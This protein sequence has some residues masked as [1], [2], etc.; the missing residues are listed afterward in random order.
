MPA[1]T[2]VASV[3]ASSIGAW[4]LG[5]F[6][7]SVVTGAIATGLA[8]VTSRIINGN[9]NKGNNSAN[10][11][12]GRI[13]VPPATNNKI[14]V[15]YGSA[16]VNGIITD[17]RLKSSDNIKNDTMYYCLVL[18]E[19]TNNYTTPSYGIE[20]V[21]WN[22]L[23]LTADP[24]D[25]E[26]VKDGRKVVDGAIVTAG[27][28]LTDTTYVI[29]K[30]GTTD[31]TALGAQTNNIGQVFTA[32]NSGLFIAG[33]FVVG[34][35]YTIV[36]LGSTNFTLIGAS[37]NTVGITFTATGV[38]VGSGTASQG[39]GQAQEED[40]KDESFVLDNTT[41][42]VE[43]RVYAGGSAAAN[44]IYPPQS[45]GQTM[46]A[47]EFWADNDGSWTSANEMKGLVFAIIKMK[48]NDKG[49]TS[50]PN[51]TFQLA[52]N[53][54]NPADVWYDYMTSVRYGAGIAAADLDTTALTA[55]RNFCAEDISYTG[56][57]LDPAGGAGTANQVLDR[58]QINGILD[59]SNQVKTNI[60]T[61]L[62]NGGAWMSY[63]VA[64][65]L[66]SPVIKKAVSA[67]VPGETA[68]YFTA[69]KS[70]TT[71]TVATFPNGR[72]EAGQSLYNSTG[73]LIGTISA[74]LAPTTG[75]TAGQV[76]RY[77]ISGAA[78]TI[79]TTTFYTVAPSLLSF[80][81][82]N[83]I[84]GISIS[85][86]RLEDLYNKVE[87]E[88]YDKYNKDQ[89]A[90]YRT[91]VASGELNPNEPANTLRMNLDLCNNSVQSDLIGQVEL[92]QSRDD[93]VI[94]FT[95]TFYGIQAQAGDVIEV[96][97]DLYGWAP[98]L[99]RVMRV[100]EQE[101]EDGGL[102][103]Q[104]QALE[105]NPDAY[106]IEPITEFTT[107]AN[108]GIGNL[109]SSVGL[110]PPENP[111]ITL[112]NPGASVPNFTFNVD[113]PST[114]GPF[115]EIEV[116]YTEG[117]DPNSVTGTI[118]PGTGSNGVPVGKGL[119][120]V[121]AVTYNS[122]NVGDYFDL[123]GVTVES[124]LTQTTISTKT[125]SSGGAIGAFTF[126]LNNVTGVVIGQK[127]TG[128]GIPS[129]A[130]VVGVSGT[131]VT[132]DKAFTVQAAGS[133]L[134]TT[135]GGTGTY[136][137]SIST[138]ASGT[139]DLFDEPLDTD[140]IFLKN[141]VPDGNAT[142]FPSPST[143][144]ILIT[145]L[146]ANSQTFR[147][148][149]LKSRLGNKKNFGGFS[150]NVPIDIDGNN[151]N[152]Q[153]NPTSAGR[154]SD[155]SD[156]NIT[157]IAEGN[158]LYYDATTSKWRNT[159]I[160]EI[161]DAPAG[162][163]FAR[164]NGILIVENPVG[165]ATN[166]FNRNTAVTDVGVS[167]LNIKATSTGTPAV[168]FGAGILAESEMANTGIE[169]VGG[170]FWIAT[171]MTD[172]A[173]DFQCQI[174]AMKNGALPDY[175]VYIDS[176]G[177]LSADGNLTLNYDQ[178]AGNAVINA[179]SGATLGT[180]TW[181]GT[182]WASSADISAP[183]AT[184]GNITVGVSTNNTITT[185]SGDLILDSVTDLV[186]VNA[187]LVVDTPGFQGGNIRSSGLN[188][189]ITISQTTTSTATPQNGLR[190][191]VESTGV[192]AVGLGT[193]LE[194]EIETASGV[195]TLAGAVQVQST[196]ITPGAESFKMEFALRSAG[197]S[198][199]R[200][201][202]DHLGN[203]Q[204]DG[205]LTVT[206]TDISTGADSAIAINRD[207]STT[208]TALSPLLLRRTTSGTPAVGI[209]TGITFS[210]ETAVGNNV[211]GG[212]ID[213][214]STDITPGSESF[215]MDFELRNGGVSSAKKMSLD[216]LGNLQID[217]DLTVTGNNIKSS[218][219][220]ALTLSGANVTVAGTLRTSSSEDVANA[221]AISLTTAV[222]YFSTT[223]S[224][225]ATL[226]AGS[227]GQ[228]KSLMMVADGGDMVV[229][230][231]NAG[232]KT[233]GTGTITF[234]DIGD[235]CLLQYINSKWFAVGVNGVTFA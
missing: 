162:D 233:S 56:A 65:G 23:R 7:L 182:T 39:T 126:L 183:S 32:T 71:L 149:F 13:Q 199:T 4:A 22:D 209:G 18:S 40:F 110:P 87:V 133:Y 222:S 82:D 78:S 220:I 148:Y 106:T 179:Y 186:D 196:D 80:S 94:E 204:I 136:Q 138:T 130:M 75:E 141:K 155:L 231:T 96:T 234:N 111:I 35:Q 16:Y 190:I 79:T 131:T 169:T 139:D 172:N 166:S 95:S 215:K 45:S 156:V 3:I 62:Q 93:L 213:V 64:T 154:L 122:I 85:S 128:T 30:I 224:E 235:S 125:F 119:M 146:P 180:L 210:T 142:V 137:V 69:S 176:D 181:N 232:W 14:P 171:D 54:A 127:P 187:S 143:V 203:L 21:V 112:P 9:Q 63:N 151:V 72:I 41:N 101:T 67:G 25:L 167:V 104:I 216:N 8:Y 74:Q 15:V 134:F 42:L 223:T 120:T 173:E 226:A 194:Y 150:P 100:K 5:S 58:Y 19:Y 191:S 34:K 83:I 200:M 158:T 76:G 140:F 170:I 48:Y 132:L 12:G 159:N 51:V 59:T 1:F 97:S 152:W 225:T 81:D 219:A 115:D 144:S 11:Q 124:Q 57:N 103:A 217:G 6:G 184:L 102:I 153:P 36:S 53:I 92:R 20:S 118:V 68:T 24:N 26:K 31:F 228:F 197:T 50:L 44:Q 178:T 98:K 168:G 38:G 73:T 229:T 147:R 129:G 175:K 28:F 195:L 70:G 2:Y 185:T 157:S 206:G 212:G 113:I 46:N 114:G 109:Y 99:F 163:E 160:L 86:T 192:P 201:E 214:I 198:L 207:S 117:W 230:V 10:T 52:N 89:K 91:S 27:A 90:Y 227:A 193:N 37:A 208:D 84:S 49:F 66:W 116:Y 161:S 164:V 218:S 61:I 211:I 107:A 221:A 189:F 77:T 60:D 121:T 29:T 202:L 135:A 145:E 108:I 17:A 188:Q 123:G 205:D 88:F 105:Y 174:S 33:S 177:N 43:L 55:W 47:Y 165:S